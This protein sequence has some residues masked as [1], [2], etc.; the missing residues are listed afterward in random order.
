MKIGFRL[1]LSG[2]LLLSGLANPNS[3][4][5][6]AGIFSALANERG[7]L[8]L[9]LDSSGNVFVT[10]FASSTVSK[11]NSSGTIVWTVSITGR[12]RAI[13]TDEL[14]NIFV[15]L[16]DTG[17][18]AKISPDG[19]TVNSNFATTGGPSNAIVRDSSGNFYTANQ[20]LHTVTKFSPTG[21]TAIASY[22]TGAN[23][24]PRSL[25]I[26]SAGN[27]YTANYDS[28][29]VS[30][31]TSA[32]TVTANYGAT[33][34]N[35]WGITVDSSGNVYTTNYGANTV[36]KILSNGT[37][38]S[39]FANIT[40]AGSGPLDIVLDPAG[41]IYTANTNSNN[42][43]KIAQSSLSATSGG[44]LTSIGTVGSGING[45][46]IDSSGN[47]YTSS[48]QSSTANAIYK[49]DNVSTSAFSLSASSESVSLGSSIAGYT[50]NGGAL[51]ISGFSIS[52]AISNGL[53]FST[54]SGLISGTPQ[55]AA[56]AVTYTIMGNSRSVWASQT[57]TLTVTAAL[58][59]PAFT[60]SD[61]SESR[62][63][64]TV[65]TGFS[66][67]STGGAIASFSINATPP[68]MS[69][70]TS[71]GTLTGTPSTVATATTYTVTATN[72][73]G[74][75]TQTFVLTVTAAVVVANTPAV[76]VPDPVQ[77]S[78]ISSCQIATGPTAGGNAYSI[79]GSFISP[80]TNV[81]VGASVLPLSSWVQTPT[82]VTITM[83]ANAFGAVPVTIYNGQ[84]PLL[85]SCSYTY[86]TPL[87]A[88]S[89]APTESSTP[90]AEQ[91]LIK[92][93]PRMMKALKLKVFFGLALSDIASAEKIKLRSFATRIVG[94][95]EKI[96]I[97]VTGYAQPTPGSENTDLALSKARASAV[98]SYLRN[99]EVDAT[100][101][102]AG[103]GRTTV[104]KASSRFVQIVASSK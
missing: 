63:V 46:A 18:I 97:T 23:S 99:A 42:V 82:S 86:I 66:A 61:S 103:A 59:A 58:A 30:K 13:I 68:G 87:V 11:V 52:P 79:S 64:N 27:L 70:D 65:A 26:D 3:A 44:A 57:F 9:T 15:T 56:T 8:Q 72:A 84:V 29:N 55:A 76:S 7:S 88:P 2:I 34:S 98:A 5:A 19:N 48:F 14:G 102:F 49:I 51:A 96:T 94:L 6:A 71:T 104:N 28:S 22:S 37:V 43:T 73:T 4:H 83:P 1:I 62:T 77:K 16:W 10:N 47:I 80:V 17:K 54:S 100:I 101:V 33:G 93:E 90:K 81:Q 74:S 41:N 39:S 38:I 40:A 21:G 67:N 50:I 91:P 45:M 36:T 89:V 69:F 60:L 95:G 78:S 32:G 24:G 53:S 25:T 20:T 85:N 75:T 31:I 35:P 12:P 92:A